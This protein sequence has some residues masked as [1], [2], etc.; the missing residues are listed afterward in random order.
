M[1]R[2]DGLAVFKNLSGPQSERIKKRFQKIF[3]D[4]DL[5]IEIKCNLKI[6]DYLDVTLDLNNGSYKPFRK[7][8]DELLYINAKSNHPP[9]VIKQLPISVESRLRQLSSNREIFEEAATQYQEALN[10]CGYNYKLSY[11]A[12]A[13]ENKSN[14]TSTRKRNIIWFNPPFSRNVSTNVAKYFLELINK[15]FP[16]NHKYRKLFNRN[17][18]KV[19]YS[20]MRNVKSI[21]NTHNKKILSK[22][23]DAN[24]KTCNCQKQ[25]SCPLKGNCL[26]ENTLYA[27]KVSSNLPNYRPKEYAGI[28]A[29]PWKLRFANHKLS[30]NK[31]E[32]AKCEIAKEVWGIK[33]QGGDFN[34]E[35]R[36]IGHAP[37]YNP[38]SQKCNLCIAEKVYIAE[39]I[40]HGTLINKRDELISK[41]MHQNKYALSR[42]KSS[43]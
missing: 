37:A 1:Y 15:H 2:D 19:S 38:T 12:P 13:N 10:K 11:A 43:D 41:C 24:K 27:G 35:W 14:S 26:S 3:N 33:E 7:P 21:V 6:V 25:A 40:E 29:P 20:S 16:A 28:S 22:S 30:F 8:N 5:Q 39:N 32:Y 36:I 42:I 31:R 18:L 17:N 23:E 4:N 9:N 34:I